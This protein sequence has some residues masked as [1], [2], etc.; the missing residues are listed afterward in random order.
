VSRTGAT[1]YTNTTVS[2]SIYGGQVP[3]FD[4]GP[5]SPLTPETR[6]FIDN[7]WHHVVIRQSNN[8]QFGTGFNIHVFIDGFNIGNSSLTSSFGWIA[9][10][11]DIDHLLIGSDV[12]PA[13]AGRYLDNIAVYNRALTYDEITEHFRAGL[14]ERQTPTQIT[15]RH[16]DGTEW[17]DATEARVWNGTEW[18]VWQAEYYDGSNWVALN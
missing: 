8:G 2:N 1:T 12:D 9:G 17:L 6:N 18:V 3:G 7:K 14:F 13:I 5:G 15:V 11:G 4:I 16:Y 10:T